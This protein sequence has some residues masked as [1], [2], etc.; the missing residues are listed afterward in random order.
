MNY[1]P[2]K[3]NY[4]RPPLMRVWRRSCWYGDNNVVRDVSL[5]VSKGEILA[6]IGPSGCGK[7]TFLRSLNRLLDLVDGAR[8]EGV[9]TLTG[10][11]IERYSPE[12]LRRRVGYVFQLPNPFPMS[13]YD[14]I[15]LPLLEHGMAR[16]RDDCKPTVDYVLDRVGLLRETHGRLDRSALSLSGGQQ[17]R[18]CIARL[19]ATG[20]DMVLL[21]EPCSALDPRST[22]VIEGE[23][24]RLK[25]E[26]AVVIV[27]HNLAQARRIADRVGFFLNGE[28]VELGSAEDVFD[29]PS[30]SRTADYLEGRFG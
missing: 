17:Q 27:T 9:A 8:T 20:P 12:T 23:L 3:F 13:I 26:M 18:L 2:T 1:Q 6:L 29:R 21:D 11:D 15:A 25:D 28:L 16:N 4:D 24:E 30:D 7:T 10:L 14:N 5:H 22:A 19:L